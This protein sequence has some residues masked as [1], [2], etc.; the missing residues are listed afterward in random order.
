MFCS[1]L[2]GQMSEVRGQRSAMGPRDAVVYLCVTL[3][4]VVYTASDSTFCLPSSCHNGGHC[5]VV[6]GA[7]HCACPTG[8]TGSL[9]EAAMTV[10]NSTGGTS[11]GTRGAVS[12]TA[13]AAPGQP[14]PSPP[15]LESLLEKISAMEKIQSDLTLKLQSQSNT[16]QPSS[17][18]DNLATRINNSMSAME[19]A[20]TEVHRGRFYFLSKRILLNHHEFQSYCNMY[21][22]YLAEINDQEEF[23]FVQNFTKSHDKTGD[24]VALGG[25]DEGHEQHW[26]LLSGG[27]MNYTNWYPTEPDATT[28]QNCLFLWKTYRWQMVNWRC[29]ELRFTKFLCEIPVVGDSCRHH[30]P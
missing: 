29:F 4:L 15:T 2:N 17:C 30:M 25:T 11:G 19:L 16:W 24:F 20:R 13:S 10:G 26:T 3:T 23:D 22:G 7:L 12:V 1:S 28:D 9:C 21:G 5:S 18:Q 6:G 14:S 27:A 8:Y